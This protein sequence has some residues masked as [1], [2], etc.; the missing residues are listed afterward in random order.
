MI[1]NSIYFVKSTPLTV[2]VGSFQ[3]IQ[4]M[5]NTEIVL[6]TLK[7]CMRKF[8]ADFFFFF[9]FFDKMAEILT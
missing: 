2:F 5:L 3:N 6:Q 9:F 4:D 7:K 1:V 8:D